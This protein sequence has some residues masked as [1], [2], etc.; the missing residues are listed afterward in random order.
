MYL[1]FMQDLGQQTEYNWGATALALLYRQLSMGAD[2]E[3]L[4][5]SR[6]LLLLQLWSW[7]RLP[8]GHPKVI[9]GKAKEGDEPDEEEDEQKVHLDYNP[10]F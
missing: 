8:L 7:S 4:E 5:I 2:K 6:P 1:E 3:G 9:F 10:V